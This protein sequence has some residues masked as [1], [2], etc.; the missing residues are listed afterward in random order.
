[1]RGCRF[2]SRCSFALESCRTEEPKLTEIRPNHWAAC[3]RI[4]SSN[5][6]IA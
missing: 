6:S 4:S 5:P 1:M 3:S 2:S